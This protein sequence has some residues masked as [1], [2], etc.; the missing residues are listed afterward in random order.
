MKNHFLKT[1]YFD[2]SKL[3]K[4]SNI[5]SIYKGWF[6]LEKEATSDEYIKEID[7]F[8][9][10]K[11]LELSEQITYFVWENGS[12]K[13][14]L[15]EAIA[16]AFGFNKEWGTIHSNYKTNNI[17]NIKNNWLKLSWQP[18][19]FKWGYFFRAE[20][21]YNFVNYLQNIDDWHS[22]TR[23]GWKN[24]HNFSHWQQFMK[25]LESMIDNVGFYV[26]DEIESALS[27]ANQLK[28]VR[29]IEH[30]VKQ[31]S[32]FIIATHSPIILGIKEKSQILSFDHNFIDEIDYEMT[33]C[34]DMYKRVLNNKI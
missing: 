17:D 28:A 7:V 26:F 21:V 25:I 18:N 34:V 19:K 20:W 11:E 13:S 22:F 14:T 33:P 1:I 8:K 4:Q 23:Y 12:W 3:W 9:N 6:D 32:Q 24:L 15:L 27:P 31:W 29:I 5:D 16:V 2:N 30:M 10:I